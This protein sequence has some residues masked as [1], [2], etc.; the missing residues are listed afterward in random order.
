MNKN[1][2]LSKKVFMSLTQS[3]WGGSKSYQTLKLQG[4]IQGHPLIIFV[5]SGSSHTFLSEKLGPVLQGVTVVQSPLKVQVAN[6]DIVSCCYTMLQ[7]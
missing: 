4:A 7:A 2:S 1:P 6:D 5:D 3:A